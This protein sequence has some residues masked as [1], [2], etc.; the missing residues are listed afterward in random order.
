VAY[1]GDFY[2][3]QVHA[4]QAI[5]GPAG[6]L[7]VAPVATS[8][9]LSGPTLI[10]LMPDDRAGARAIASWLVEAGVSD[11]LVVHDHD[12]GYGAPVGA[13]CVDAMRDRG[14]RARPRPVWNYDES[15]ADDLGGAGA[16]LYAGVAGSGAER[17]WHDLHTSNPDLWLLGTDG[18][19]VGW[20]A[21]A[22]SPAAAARTR[23]FVPQKEPLGFYG[24]AAMSLIL[25][26]VAEG[27]DDRREVVRVAR[28]KHTAPTGYGCLAVVDGELVSA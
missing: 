21:E 13:M 6:L 19:A 10:C 12:P 3:S 8:V 15:P 22:L 23:F 5:L 2:S 17:L 16:V 26:A 1:L 18:V 11:L 14:L 9:E 24:E 7:Q 4:A 20:L 28:A 27:G 25:D